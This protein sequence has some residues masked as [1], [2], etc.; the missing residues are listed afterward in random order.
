MATPEDVAFAGLTG[1]AELVRRGEISSRELTEL[2]IERIVR[3]D[4]QLNAFRVVLAERA[5]EEAD[6]ADQRRAAG[7][8]APLLGVPVAAK[9]NVDVAGEVTTHGTNAYGGAAIEDAEIVK[10]LRGAGAV[11]VGKT[12]LPEL[13]IWPFTSSQAWGTTRNPWDVSRSA[14]GSSGGAAAAVASGMVAAAHASDGGGSIRIPAACCGL[15]GLKPQ[16]GRVSLMPDAEHWYGLSVFG[17]LT[18]TVG[19][20]ALFLDVVR[21]HVDGDAHTAPDPPTSFA[22]AARTAPGKLRIAFSTKPVAP[23]PVADAV[24]KAVHDTADVLRSLGH[25]VREQNPTWG[26]QVPGFLPRYLAGI[27]DDTNRMAHPERLEQRTRRLAGIGE[28]L[29]RRPLQRA[30][31]AEQKHARRLGALFAEF[32]VLMTPTMARLPVEADRWERAGMVSTINGV[33]RY[34]PFT[35][36]W[37]LTGQPAAAVPAGFSPEGLPLSVQL[38]GRPAD[39]TTLLSLSAQLEA[40]RPWSDRRPPVS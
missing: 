11:I 18:R 9:D 35:T 28:R 10:R 22:E 3:L 16:R 29:R 33:S 26:L 25:D 5:L 34:V 37:N 12:N 1:Q 2:S 14:G 13:A 32:D 38:V 31:R 4:R 17:C 20:S 40:A 6:R 23:G 30:L 15:F 27:R 39:E 8:E 36:P 7:E 21:G 24:K 19:D